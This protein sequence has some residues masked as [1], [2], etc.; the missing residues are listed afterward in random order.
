MNLKGIGFP[1][2]L[3]LGLLAAAIPAC[4]LKKTP[5]EKHYFVL[6]AKRPENIEPQ[7]KRKSQGNGVFLQIDRFRVSPRFEGKGLV[8]RTG[9]LSYEAD[10]YNEFL[11]EPSRLLAEETVHWLA[12]SDLFENVIPLGIN[13][14]EQY[15]L[16]GRVNSLYGDYR[17]KG[18]FRGV[19]EIEFFLLRDPYRKVEVLLNKKY[20]HE[21]PMT[22]LV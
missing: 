2:L 12:A 8:Y 11:V 18:D 1:V 9:D 15:A 22:G 21:T 20:H 6:E 10:F 13:M 16:A 4:S 7:G 3:M 5:P 19:M 14:E 17:N